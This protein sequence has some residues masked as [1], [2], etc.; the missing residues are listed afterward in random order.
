MTPALVLLLACGVTPQ[1]AYTTA[2]STCAAFPIRST[3]TTYYYCRCDSGAETGCQ[4]GSGTTGCTAG[5]PCLGTW[6]DVATRFRSM[7]GGDTIALCKG[8]AWSVDT[9]SY[10]TNYFNNSACGIGAGLLTDPANASTCD[11][12]DYA[13]TCNGVACVNK[14]LLSVGTGGAGVIVH[15]G[16]GVST[17]GVRILNLEFRGTSWPLN[18]YSNQFAIHMGVTGGAGIEADWLICNDEFN[19]LWEGIETTGE[20]NAP[21]R[22]NITGNRFTYNFLDA[23]LGSPGPNGRI[24]GNVFDN[25]GG[26]TA[27]G[28]GQHHTLYLCQGPAVEHRGVQITGNQFLRTDVASSNVGSCGTTMMESHQLFP[29]LVIENN[30][31]DS[32]TSTG[33]GCWLVMLDNNVDASNP[34]GYDGLRFRRNW[35]NGRAGSYVGFAAS[36]VAN[37]II[38]NNIILGVSQGIHVPLQASKSPAES[39]LEVQSGNNQ[40]RNNTIYLQGGTNTGIQVNIEGSGYVIANNSVYGASGGATCFDAPLAA[41]A[42]TFVGNNACR[43]GTYYSAGTTYVDGTPR[44]TA[45]PQY[46]NAPTDFRLQLTSPLRDAGT[47]TYTP[48]VDYNGFPRTNPPDIGAYEY[49]STAGSLGSLSAATST[50]H[51]APRFSLSGDTTQVIL[52]TFLSG[53]K[54]YYCTGSAACTPARSAATQYSTP[55]TVPSGQTICARAWKGQNRYPIACST[56]T[57]N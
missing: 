44:I 23:I 26:T 46:A 54:L 52:S 21:A 25:N 4:P 18:Q 24:E 27:G 32:G 39:P 1:Q 33:A 51:A 31:F 29:D 34:T 41:G 16:S 15:W 19:H 53:A 17:N 40:I 20:G 47:V 28:F 57:V 37:G 56:Y 42:Y 22:W 38:E 5:A 45:D 11:V 14:P 50:V 3:G 55:V 7:S 43:N 8:G 48:T 30:Y 12:R 13:A 2:S 49:G 10:V 6:A 35:M 9:T 36:N